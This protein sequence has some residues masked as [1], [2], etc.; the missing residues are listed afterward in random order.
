MSRSN[1]NSIVRR[2]LHGMCATFWDVRDILFLSFRGALRAPSL[3]RLDAAQAQAVY[4]E[5]V[6]R[7]PCPLRGT[8]LRN[9]C[10]QDLPVALVAQALQQAPYYLKISRVDANAEISPIPRI[11]TPPSAGAF[12][13][14]KSEAAEATKAVRAHPAAA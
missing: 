3:A 14:A 1:S 8:Q 10:A 2:R 12:D 9:F 5:H 11:V 6:P 4:L 13:R 7:R